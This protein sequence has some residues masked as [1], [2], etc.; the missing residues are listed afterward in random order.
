MGQPAGPKLTPA[1]REKAAELIAKATQHLLQPS[2]ERPAV[3]GIEDQHRERFVAVDGWEGQ[4]RPEP[5]I[6][7]LACI[8][9]GRAFGKILDAGP[10]AA[11]PYGPNDP[12]P[13]PKLG[14][15]ALLLEVTHLGR[16]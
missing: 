4:R 16:G 9:G 3:P 10:L 6:D 14:F 8:V 13:R 2:G 12:L 11:A 1:T 15:A 7:R 5:G